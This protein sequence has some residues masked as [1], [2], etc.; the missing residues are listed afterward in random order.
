MTLNDTTND[1]HLE[2]D[3]E[4]TFADLGVIPEICEALAQVGIVHPF[5]IQSLAIPIAITGSDMIG[6]ARTGTGKT[7]AFGISLLQ[8][9]T[10]PS[11]P[12]YDALPV[13]GSPQALVMC[14]TREL[15][16]QVTRDLEVAAS[17]R[18]ARVLTV[19]GGVGYDTQLDTRALRRRRRRRRNS[20]APAGLAPAAQPRLVAG[21]RI[22]AR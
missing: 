12:G 11:D 9:I 21:S 18:V 19:Y 7:F 14:P 5:P 20:R 17:V 22:G 15:A 3:E 16:L 6:Q 10:V 8:R 2:A 1:L 4:H 13:K